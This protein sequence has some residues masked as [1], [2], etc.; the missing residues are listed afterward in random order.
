MQDRIITPDEK[1][2]IK[3]MPPLS[4]YPD[5]GKKF[6]F[7][8]SHVIQFFESE[9]SLN[10]RDAVELFESARRNKWILFDHNSKEWMGKE[11]FEEKYGPKTDSQ[12]AP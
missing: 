1:R 3:T 10:Q 9:F 5:R 6:S 12:K 11:F 7:D 4:H 8:N 2:L